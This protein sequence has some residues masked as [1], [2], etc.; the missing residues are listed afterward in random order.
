MFCVVLDIH[1]LCS[2]MHPRFK[3]TITAALLIKED[4]ISQEESILKFYLLYDI[5]TFYTGFVH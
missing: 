1:V 5:Y 2:I 4:A 3:I